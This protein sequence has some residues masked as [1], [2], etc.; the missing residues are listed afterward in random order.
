MVSTF[1]LNFDNVA[2]LIIFFSLWLFS[3]STEFVLQIGSGKS[4]WAWSRSQV[5]LSLSIFAKLPKF[6]KFCPDF[7][8]LD[9]PWKELLLVVIG[10]DTGAEICPSVG[11]G[12]AM[13][14]RAFRGDESKQLGWFLSGAV[15][16]LG[17]NLISLSELWA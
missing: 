6:T 13:L 5:F 9:G 12:N 4:S 3:L 7:S 2:F 8:G 15:S 14:N 1:L 17:K 11:V 16:D 10:P